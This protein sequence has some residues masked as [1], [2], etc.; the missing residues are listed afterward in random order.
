MVATRKAKVRPMN[1]PC[2]AQQ[3][4]LPILAQHEEEEDMRAEKVLNGDQ[5]GCSNKTILVASGK[6]EETHRRRQSCK[7]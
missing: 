2:L 1:L 5:F 4:D 6:D 7:A 3:E